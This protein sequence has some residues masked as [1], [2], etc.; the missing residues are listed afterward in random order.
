MPMEDFILGESVWFLGK[1]DDDKFESLAA[2]TGAPPSLAV[3]MFTDEDL[4]R[5]AIAELDAEL[6]PVKIKADVALLGIMV[7]LER[8]GCTHVLIDQSFGKGQFHAIA[9][10]IREIAAWFDSEAEPGHGL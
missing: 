9:R 10:L 3:M 8:K 5:R 7:I 4:A 1:P 2:Y 6:T